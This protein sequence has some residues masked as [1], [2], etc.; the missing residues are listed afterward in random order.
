MQYLAEE[1]DPK[2]RL[3]QFSCANKAEA[4]PKAS[5]DF[6]SIFETITLIGPALFGA[7]WTGAEL[8]AVNWP[9]SPRESHKLALLSSGGG[10]PGGARRGWS[11]P[12]KSIEFTLPR[13]WTHQQNCHVTAWYIEKRQSKWEQNMGAERRLREAVNWL[14]QRCRDGE[15]VSHARFRS[16]GSLWPMASWEWNLDCPSSEHLAQSGARISGA[17]ASSGV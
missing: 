4:W 9:V 1:N 10:A 8:D 7:E 11:N 6:A 3:I 13:E 2:N 15:I 12:S 16:G 17:L 14:A 5:S